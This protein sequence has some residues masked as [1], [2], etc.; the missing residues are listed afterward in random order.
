MPVLALPAALLAALL[1]APAPAPAALLFHNAGTLA[2]W[3]AVRRE[4]RGTVAEVANVAHAA[5]PAL[6]MTQTYDARHRGRFHAEVVRADGYRRGDE[7]FYAFA[8]RLS[9]AWQPQPQPYNLAQFIARRPGTG[10]GHA[11]WAPT[12]MLWIAGDR[13]AARLVSGPYRGPTCAR[14]VVVLPELAAVRP[15]AWHAVVVHARWASDASGFF[16][17]RFDGALVA[18]LN[19]LPTTL[20]DDAL[21]QF[22][23]GLYANGWHDDARIDGTQFFRQVWFDDIAIGTEFADVDFARG[24]RSCSSCSSSAASSAAPFAPSTVSSSAS[25]PASASTSSSPPSS[26]PTTP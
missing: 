14:D 23:V 25:S 2:G 20:D 11:D 9:A 8:F 17:L 4:H 1:L 21:F 24:N 18:E 12:A 15:G 5:P 16:R 7:R 26:A 13:L 6:K 22:R 19:G 3:D 10:C